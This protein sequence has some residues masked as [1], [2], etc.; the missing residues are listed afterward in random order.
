LAPLSVGKC[1]IRYR[2][3]EEIDW[4]LVTS[5]LKSTKATDAENCP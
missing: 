1:C 5:L 2:Q 3:P 4:T